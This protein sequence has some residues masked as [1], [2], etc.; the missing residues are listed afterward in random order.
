MVNNHCHGVKL[1]FP[2]E[3]GYRFQSSGNFLFLHLKSEPGPRSQQ[4]TLLF[5]SISLPPPPPPPP[6]PPLRLS[7]SPHTLT[8]TTQVDATHICSFQST[9][10]LSVTLWYSI[11]FKYQNTSLC[12]WDEGDNIAKSITASL[13]CHLKLTTAHC[14][15][16]PAQGTFAEIQASLKK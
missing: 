3:Q 4:T 6:P 13:L 15:Q 1:P 9:T 16:N 10:S 14:T 2:G 7:W 11:C 5:L 8:H 12:R